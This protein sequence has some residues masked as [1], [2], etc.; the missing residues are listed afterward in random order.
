[1]LVLLNRFCSS[2]INMWIRQILKRVGDAES[3]NEAWRKNIRQ[4]HKRQYKLFQM[5][6]KEGIVG[7][8]FIGVVTLMNQMKKHGHSIT[9]QFVVEK[10]MRPLLLLHFGTSF[11]ALYFGGI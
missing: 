11:M 8:F 5:K 6:E 4:N 3:T 2:F 7:E 9:N 10:I 1:M